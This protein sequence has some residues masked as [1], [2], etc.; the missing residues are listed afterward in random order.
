MT[1]VPDPA[2]TSSAAERA[3]RAAAPRPRVGVLHAPHGAAGLH[4]IFA[5]ARGLCDVVLLVRAPVAAAHPELVAAAERIFEVRV[6]PPGEDHGRAL[7]L[8]G[9]VTFHDA[10]L[11]HCDRIAADLGLRTAPALASAWDK[12]VQRQV[13]ARSGISRVTALPVE[14]ADDFVAACD[15]LAGPCVLKPRRGAS[16]RGIAFIED[17]EDVAYQ[18]ATRRQWTGHLVETMIAATGHPTGIP[19]LSDFTSVETVSHAGARHHVAMFDKTPISLVRRAGQDGGDSIATTGDLT[20]SR[21]GA[22][23]REKALRRVDAALDA[24]GVRWRVTHTELWIMGDDVEIIEVNGRVGGHLN[25][26][27]RL[28]GGPDLVRCALAAAAGIRLPA[29]VPLATGYAAG[30]FM[31]FPQRDG[32]VRA[33]VGRGDIRR[34]PGVVGVDEVAKQGEPRSAHGYRMANFTV[35]A[36]DQDTFDRCLRDVFA[37]VARLFEADGLIRDPWMGRVCPSIQE[38]REN[39]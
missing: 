39:S 18:L 21:L 17:G 24:L 2:V 8:D 4:D 31:P 7:R 28:T 16:G 25:R 5:A 9:V 1:T 22:D 38:E 11:D 37:G 6:L 29:D 26:L 32:L 34:L 14:S 3:G 20:P 33:D 13:L 19:W 10:E 35:F 36:E 30:L 27:L 23:L 12:L 15:V